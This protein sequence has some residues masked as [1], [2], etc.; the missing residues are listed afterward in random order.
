MNKVFFGFLLVFVDF[1][2]TING[3]TLN[4]FP[5]WVGYCLIYSGLN[6]LSGESDHFSLAKPW[7]LGMVIY[8]AILWVLE[9]FMGEAKLG[10]IG[11]LLSLA[12]VLVSLYVS[13]MIIQGIGDIENK[14]D[15]ALEQERLKKVWMLYAICVIAA[16]GLV[17]LAPIAIIC[18]IVAFVAAVIFL[19]RFNNTRKAYN[20]A[21]G[22]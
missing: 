12:A 15:I 16:Q 6:D 22:L 7:C 3:H 14:R 21:M 2:L 1:N 9:A 4:I 17:I 13:Y 18:L 5:D 11:W 19:V 8:N 10:I 20:Q